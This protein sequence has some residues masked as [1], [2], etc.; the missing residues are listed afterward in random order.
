VRKFE[1]TEAIR[2]FQIEDTKAITIENDEL[3]FGEK[4]HFRNEARKKI[5]TQKVQN[6][7]NQCKFTLLKIKEIVTKNI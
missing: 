4:K 2:H 7:T 5:K 1:T 3:H 6:R